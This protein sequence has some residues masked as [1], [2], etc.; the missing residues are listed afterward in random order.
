MKKSTC[1]IFII[2]GIL[3][4][5]PIILSVYYLN[6]IGGSFTIIF[7]IPSLVLAIIAPFLLIIGILKWNSEEE[8]AETLKSRAKVHVHVQGK[9]E[10]IESTG[11]FCSDCGAKVKK[12]A[13]FCPE[14]GAK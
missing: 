12:G 10:D 4:L 3:F 9:M 5:I 2:L 13:K 11:S 8:K 14:C 7:G 1:K 6:K